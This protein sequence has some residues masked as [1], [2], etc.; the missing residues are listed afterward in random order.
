MIG[1]VHVAAEAEILGDATGLPLGVAQLV[2]YALSAGVVF[3]G[4]RAVGLFE[5]VGV[6]ALIGCV[7]V[8]A[9]GALGVEVDLPLTADGSALDDLALGTFLNL[10]IGISG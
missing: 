7:I 3:F 5:T 4:L 10:S 2:V 9:L 1:S 6:V 8:L